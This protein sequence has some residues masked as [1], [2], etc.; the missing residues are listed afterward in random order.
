[1]SG[2]FRRR[3]SRGWVIAVVLLILWLGYRLW[4]DYRQDPTPEL[5]GEQ[6][7]AVRYV[8]DG[9]TLILANNARVRLL[10]IDAPERAR[11]GQPAEPFSGQA[12]DFVRRF[13]GRNQ[14]Q[15]RFDRERIDQYGRFL[16]YVYVD[17]Q[18]LNEAILRAGMARKRTDFSYSERYKR[19]FR[20]AEE[21]A[22]RRK[23]G[24]WDS[25]HAP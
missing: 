18:L 13:I 22:Q 2:R 14:V 11:D 7:Y 16:A 19:I 17:E 8:I 12:T 3:R 4:Q 9:D 20:A 10:G 15:L 24:I 25:D 23:I 5:L 1:M 6:K 21:D